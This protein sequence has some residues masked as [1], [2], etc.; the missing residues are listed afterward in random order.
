MM[1]ASS[2]FKDDVKPAANG[3]MNWAAIL[4]DEDQWIEAGCPIGGKVI[5]TAVL[6]QGRYWEGIPE[7]VKSYTMEYT[8]NGF[9]FKPYMED[10]KI[11]VND[12]IGCNRVLGVR[13]LDYDITLKKKLFDF[14]PYKEDQKGKNR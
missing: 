12:I 6:T 13:E 7:F 1:D 2:R 14:K 10:G 4:A 9:D 5:V 3:L 11:K 8:E